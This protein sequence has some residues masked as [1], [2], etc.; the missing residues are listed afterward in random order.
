MATRWDNK[1]AY[2]DAGDSKRDVSWKEDKMDK[3]AGKKLDKKDL[4]KAS[5]GKG[6]APKQT[7]D[8]I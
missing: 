6:G 4:K 3:F 5:G 7:D 2:K 8:N 1:D